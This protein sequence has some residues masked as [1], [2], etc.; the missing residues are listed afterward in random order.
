MAA[1]CFRNRKYLYLMHIIIYL[2]SCY[3]CYH[4]M[5]KLHASR[6]NINTSGVGLIIGVVTPGSQSW[7]SWILLSLDLG[8]SVEE[9]NLEWKSPV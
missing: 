1:V 7:S 6:F 3:S 4:I 9:V 8:L 2:K 5:N